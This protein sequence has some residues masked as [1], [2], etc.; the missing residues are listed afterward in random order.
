MLVP[1]KWKFFL[2]LTYDVCT[3]VDIY[4]LHVCSHNTRHISILT[5][6]AHIMYAKPHE[7]LTKCEIG[8]KLGVSSKIVKN[9]SSRL[10]V[11]YLLII[12][13]NSHDTLTTIAIKSMYIRF[14]HRLQ[15]F[16]QPPGSHILWLFAPIHMS[17]PNYNYVILL[18]SNIAQNNSLGNHTWSLFTS[19]HITSWRTVQLV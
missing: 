19:I 2:C 5:G 15:S 7:T 13:L 14:E 17:W 11:T 1:Y 9:H 16:V 8:S 18:G 6:L 12:G 4:N 3:F 10:W